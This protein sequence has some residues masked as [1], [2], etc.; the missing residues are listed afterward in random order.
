MNR[1]PAEIDVAD[2]RAK[3]GAL[4]QP[5]NAVFA[6]ADDSTGRLSDFLDR[7]AFGHAIGRQVTT[8]WEISSLWKA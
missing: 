1:A 2:S 4:F 8:V 5:K 7:L 6:P 3:P